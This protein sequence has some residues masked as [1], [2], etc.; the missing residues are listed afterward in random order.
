MTYSGWIKTS[1]VSN[2]AG[3]WWRVDGPNG[4]L[5]FNNMF[6]S[7]VKG[8]RDWKR[9]SFSIPVSDS[10]TSLDFGVIMCGMNGTAW[11]DDLSIDTNGKPYAY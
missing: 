4:A 1:H 9:Y 8:D 6:D 7:A 2:W 10:A 3:L 5:A 11:F